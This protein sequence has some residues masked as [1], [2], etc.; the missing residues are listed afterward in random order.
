[1]CFVFFSLFIFHVNS[2]QME[3]FKRWKHACQM[4]RK[5]KMAPVVKRTRRKRTITCRSHVCIVPIRCFFFFFYMSTI[6]HLKFSWRHFSFLFTC[7]YIPPHSL[8]F[9]NLNTIPWEIATSLRMRC[10]QRILEGFSSVRSSVF[11]VNFPAFVI[12]SR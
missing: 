5:S 6:E 10:L 2:F 11:T 4:E 8:A 9:L 7:S 1:M 3:M 12:I